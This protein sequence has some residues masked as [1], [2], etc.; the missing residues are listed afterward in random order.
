MR[1]IH[2]V[3][4]LALC[5]AAPPAAA[6]PGGD[7]DEHASEVAPGASA[8]EDHAPSTQTQASSSVEPPTNP[9]RPS[10]AWTS[11]QGP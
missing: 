4:T 8:S 9:C 7:P 1:T 11:P 3:A 6:D 2:I 5:L 10:C